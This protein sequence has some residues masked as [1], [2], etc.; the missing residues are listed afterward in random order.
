[1]LGTVN[2]EILNFLPNDKIDSITYYMC[3][4]HFREVKMR[5]LARR[6]FPHQKTKIKFSFSEVFE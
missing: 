2:P 1:M 4:N 5:K 3:H 6:N